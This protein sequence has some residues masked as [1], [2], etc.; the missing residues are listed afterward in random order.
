MRKFT[1]D[2]STWRTGQDGEN[3]TGE[4]PTLLHNHQGFMC[5][6][7]QI[8][9][10]CGIPKDKLTGITPAQIDPEYKHKVL[11]IGLL[12]DPIQRSSQLSILA[13]NINDLKGTTPTQKEEHLI[14]LFK[15]EN[16]ELEFVGEYHIPEA[17][18]Q[19]N[20][21]NYHQEPDYDTPNEE[22]H[23]PENYPAP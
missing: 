20:D 9:L 19:E 5:C 22:Y 4:G 21:E 15:K 1:I 17:D 10:Q 14:E 12:Q 11:D 16:L 6:L 8:S 3:K 7:G 18:P 2:R 13:M 23:G